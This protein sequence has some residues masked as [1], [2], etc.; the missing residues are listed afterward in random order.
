[1][2]EPV[3]KA[4]S[5]FIEKAMTDTGQSLL[6][7]LLSPHRLA[8]LDLNV[9]K[10]YKAILLDATLRVPE[11]KARGLKE[12]TGT[13]ECLTAGDTRQVDLGIVDFKPGA[14]G[15]ELD[16]VV[17]SVAPDT[18]NKDHTTMQLGLKT[19]PQAVKS[20]KFFTEEGKQLDV[21]KRGWAE[22]ETLPEVYFKI[23][24]KLPER[25]RIVLEVFQDLENREVSFRI[26]DVTLTGQP[27]P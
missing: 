25:G 20:A 2:N 15:R 22:S 1:M 10:D 13:L 11:D 8:R 18:W 16:A 7:K 12:V 19:E 5:G 27:L 3:L 26:S 24:D 9:A 4:T 6:P 17:V 23:K 21:T 14:K